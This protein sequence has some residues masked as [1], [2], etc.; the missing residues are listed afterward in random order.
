MIPFATSIC[1]VLASLV[2]C[3]Y[4]TLPRDAG[5]KRLLDEFR[6]QELRRS[7]KSCGIEPSGGGF[8][9]HQLSLSVEDALNEHPWSQSIRLRRSSSGQDESS[10]KMS[11]FDGEIGVFRPLSNAHGKLPFKDFTADMWVKPEGGQNHPAVLIGM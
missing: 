7:Y 9:D 6:Q 11:Y 2:S 4:G 1:I 10:V 5:Y 3:A 8:L